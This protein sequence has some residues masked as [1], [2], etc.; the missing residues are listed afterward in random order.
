M[1]EVPAADLV[2]VQPRVPLGGLNDIFTVHRRPATPTRCLIATW[3]GVEPRYPVSSPILSLLAASGGSGRASLGVRRGAQRSILGVSDDAL[4]NAHL[5]RI[6]GNYFV[7]RSDR[8][9]GHLVTTF[10]LNCGTGRAM[11]NL[12]GKV[13]VADPCIPKRR[14]CRHSSSPA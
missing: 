13:I 5:I 10:V 2:L 1:P 8:R 7:A 6:D 11:P 12:L 9:T 4:T 3:R 14:I